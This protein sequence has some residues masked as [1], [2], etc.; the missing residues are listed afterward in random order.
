M[1]KTEI[2]RIRDSK[3]MLGQQLAGRMG[4]SPARI[5]V[6]ERDEQ[7]GAVTLKMM[8]RAAEA[9]DCEFIYALVPKSS[10]NM[11]AGTGAKPKLKLQSS[12]DA[13]SLDARLRQL[14]DQQ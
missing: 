14:L 7:K 2:R 3:N 12:D 11:P 4:V 6:L 5:S 10:A 1:S 9:L 13:Q 8:T